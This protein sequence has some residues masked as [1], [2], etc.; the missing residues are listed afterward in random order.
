MLGCGTT[1]WWSLWRCDPRIH[2][3]G[4][5]CDCHWHLL[6]PA[7][8]VGPRVGFGGFGHVLPFAQTCLC[9]TYLDG[10]VCASLGHDDADGTCT[11]YECFKR[12]GCGSSVLQAFDAGRAMWLGASIELRP[13]FDKQHFL[14]D[15]AVQRQPRTH[16]SPPAGHARTLRTNL[17]MCHGLVAALYNSEAGGSLGHRRRAMTAG[18]HHVL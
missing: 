8:L 6:G 14:C 5:L 2:F 12:P 11:G 4:M 16:H 13:D 7:H 10:G 9:V 3:F 1:R 17:S 18:S 15:K